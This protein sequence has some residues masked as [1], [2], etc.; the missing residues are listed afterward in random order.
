M[1]GQWHPEAINEHP[2][3][4]DRC[5]LIASSRRAA[6]GDGSEVATDEFAEPASPFFHTSR[7]GRCQGVRDR[8]VLLGGPDVGLL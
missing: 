8:G 5:R 6:A 3:R 7:F 1:S 2:Q 4:H